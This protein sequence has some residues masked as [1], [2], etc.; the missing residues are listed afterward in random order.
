MFVALV[1]SEEITHSSYLLWKK[2][3]EQFALS[4]FNSKARIW[5]RFQ[6]LIYNNSL[7]DFIANTQKCL[8]DIS[9][10]GISVEEEI[11]AF[12]IF[13]K[14]PEESHLL[15]E[16]VILNADTQG[17]PDTILNVLHEATLK[18]EA[19]PRDTTRALVRKKEDSPSK[20]VGYCSNGRHNPLVNTHG[21]EKCWKLYPKL[22]PER[23]LKENFTIAQALV[24]HES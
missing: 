17:N 15:I 3:K 23:K 20:I 24:I 19:L 14:L 9:S 11:L 6:K 13:T 1:T 2:L 7:K 10:V 16:K 8:S 18:E 22:R 5:S 12:S 21:P 4:S